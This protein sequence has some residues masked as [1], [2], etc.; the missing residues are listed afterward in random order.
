M[1]NKTFI[2]F[3]YGTLMRGEQN[4]YLLDDARFIGAATTKPKY[5]LMAIDGNYP[6]PALMP[7]GKLAVAG[8][9]YECPIETQAA[10]DQIEGHPFNYCRMPIELDG[11]YAPGKTNIEAVAYFLVNKSWTKYS[12]RIESGDWRRR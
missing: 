4:H 6:F 10:M 11:L 1:E 5:D 12:S 9:L 8:E 7:E 2:L 3:T